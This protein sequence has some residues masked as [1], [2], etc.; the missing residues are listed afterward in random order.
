MKEREED[1]KKKEGRKRSDKST[2]L[3]STAMI[4]PKTRI[5]Q[6]PEFL[7]NTRGTV[8]GMFHDCSFTE[9][10]TRIGRV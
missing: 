7:N 9:Y 10:S 8:I 4:F 5:S 2:T 1:R 3:S 6:N